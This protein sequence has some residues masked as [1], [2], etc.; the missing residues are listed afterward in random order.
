MSGYHL[1][2]GIWGALSTSGAPGPPAVPPPPPSPTLAHLNHDAVPEAGQFPALVRICTV[3]G[4]H[5][6]GDQ[7]RV[8]HHLRRAGKGRVQRGWVRR[9]GPPPSAPDPH[10][11]LPPQATP[12]AAPT[13]PRPT[14]VVSVGIGRD[15]G[16]ALE[17]VDDE[18]EHQVLEAEGGRER[19]RY[20]FVRAQPLKPHRSRDGSVDKNAIKKKIWSSLVAQRVKDPA[21]SLL[22]SLLWCNGI[23]SVSGA[24]SRRFDTQLAQ[25]VKDL[26]AAAA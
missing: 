14:H 22:R 16:G 20:S 3:E 10:Q 12:S 7:G 8:R 25:W 13:C 2:V 24:L 11:L 21:V 6:L 4:Q 9:D 5:L 23:G 18:H 15:A 26:T 17:D 19:Q 1:P